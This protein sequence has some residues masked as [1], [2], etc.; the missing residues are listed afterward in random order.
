[1]LQQR[2]RIALVRPLAEW[3]RLILDAPGIRE[4]PVTGDE[5]L[6]AV[7]LPGRLHA[8][9]ADRILVATARLQRCTLVTRDER[10]LE[11]A[12]TGHVEALRA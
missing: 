8:D 7:S 2:R 1:M 9:P 11:Y 5:A 12:E 3:R 6:E 4:L 10:L